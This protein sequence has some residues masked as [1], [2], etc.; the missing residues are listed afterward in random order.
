M[1]TDGD[2][3]TDAE[4]AIL[5][6]D[7]TIADSD[8]DGLPDFWEVAHGL[9]PHD[10]GSI[11]P[12]NGP[13]GDPDG[14]S[15]T[16]LT[17]YL[18][19]SNPTLATSIPAGGIDTAVSVGYPP[20]LLIETI[21]TFSSKYG[22][23]GFTNYSGIPGAR[24]RYLHRFYRLESTETYDDGDGGTLEITEDI[25]PTNGTITS[26]AVTTGNGA[27]NYGWPNWDVADDAHRSMTGTD[28]DG[29][30]ETS[31]ATELLA[32]EYTTELFQILTESKLP[33]YTGVYHPYDFEVAAIS[34][35]PQPSP[36]A[37]SYTLTKLKYKWELHIKIGQTITMSANAMN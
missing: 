33:G 1:D 10:N 20:L 27:N 16:N 2:G 18:G 17:E 7:P 14:D 37:Y 12:T 19:G 30:G 9:N 13:N 6:T 24:L 35:S 4:E 25:D 32:N 23:E 11:N 3:Y 5:H 21:S 36:T 31:T 26:D 22:F 34:L 15:Y 29:S 28:D 8:A